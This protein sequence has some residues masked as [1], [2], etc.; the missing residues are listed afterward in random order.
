MNPPTCN[1]RP[2]RLN[3]RG[4]LG[5]GSGLAAAMAAGPV[6]A[7]YSAPATAPPPSGLPSLPRDFFWGAATS[8]YQI[9]GAAAIDGRKPSVWDTFSK[10]RD[11]LPMAIPAMSPVITTTASRRT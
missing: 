4:F 2:D 11:A 8:F 6:I 10:P 9:E 3:R 1:N 5:A 7:N